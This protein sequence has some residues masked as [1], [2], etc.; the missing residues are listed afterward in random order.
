MNVKNIAYGFI[1]IGCL[2]TLGWAYKQAQPAHE[3]EYQS[4]TTSIKHAEMLEAKLAQQM[5]SAR[6]GLISNYDPI[7]KTTQDIAANAHAMSESAK[8]S[9]TLGKTAAEY[10]KATASRVDNV[11]DFK[12]YNSLLRNSLQYLP[13]VGNETTNSN[14]KA[15]V[16]AILNYSATG[17]DLAKKQAE[18]LLPGLSAQV[19]ANK[20][21]A[22]N[23][24]RLIVA[25]SK[26]SLQARAEID[27][28]F[29]FEKRLDTPTL[30]AKFE[31]GVKAE[32][33]Q[34]R[35]AAAAYGR[36][37]SFLTFGVLFM[38][39]WAI[40]KWRKSVATTKAAEVEI[41]QRRAER[42]AEMEQVALERE[43]ALVESRR[44]NNELHQGAHL[45]SATG[46][47]LHQSAETSKCLVEAISA[48]IQQVREVAATSSET[49][50]SVS[51]SSAEQI[52]LA[53]EGKAEASQARKALESLSESAKQLDE[54]AEVAQQE[55]ESGSETLERAIK[56]L[57][58]LRSQVQDT[59]AL[60]TE[61]GKKSESIDR[62]TDMIENIAKQTN[63]LALNAAIEAARAGEH[64]RGFSVVADEVRKLAESSSLSSREIST[65][66]KAI[67]QE[68]MLAVEAIEIAQA[69]ATATEEE[70]LQAS[71]ALQTIQKSAEIVAAEASSVRSQ[72]EAVGGSVTALSDSAEQIR[73]S[74]KRSIETS[75]ELSIASKELN[76]QAED[77]LSK[78]ADQ[79]HVAVLI[80][81]A[82][83]SLLQQA[84][85]LAH[86]SSGH[87]QEPKAPVRLAA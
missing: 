22:F 2:G 64:G 15:L 23:P 44:I 26:T 83:E 52:R 41:E 18:N 30:L 58:N 82:A 39:V 57:T 5:L 73:E 70:S 42:Q 48:S 85:E 84:S 35:Q 53:E 59:A 80:S 9:G 47:S 51:D 32:N 62:I 19:M 69:E 65:L 56:R 21:N 17:L 36:I 45:L 11:D 71:K 54:A 16:V 13:I 75:Q 3:L 8:F 25:H 46:S 1:A 61:L 14:A 10:E 77:V 40:F 50:E 72:V 60:V 87:E 31:N 34:S 86:V 4:L 79:N 63:L 67:I 6:F 74:A 66:V 78:V 43:A 7:V 81:E 29:Q 33:K 37:L 20:D 27:G 24:E 68:V 55:S 12:Q 76:E 49:S 28:V 38:A